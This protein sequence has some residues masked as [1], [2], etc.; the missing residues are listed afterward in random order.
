MDSI[1]KIGNNIDKVITFDQLPSKD[2][3]GHN[4][5]QISTPSKQDNKI[6]KLHEANPANQLSTQEQILK[7]IETIYS[8]YGAP[9]T[10]R[11]P[12]QS[13]SKTIEAVEELANLITNKSPELESDDV[14]SGLN[15]LRFKMNQRLENKPERFSFIPKEPLAIVLNKEKI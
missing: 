11:L 14:Q 3:T 13:Q 5:S 4:N 9:E 6:I 1:N 7:N 2:E 8:D 15:N 10:M 12:F